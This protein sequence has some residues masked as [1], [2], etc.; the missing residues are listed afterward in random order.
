MFWD[1]LFV[2]PVVTPHLPAVTRALLDYRWRRLD[3]ARQAARRPGW[4][5]AL[6]PWQSGSDGREETP[7][8]LFNL[9]SGRWMPDNSR[10]QRHVGLAV[11][12]NAWQYYQ[13]TGDAA[14]LAERGAELI[15]EVARLFAS[16]ATYD[17]ADDRY[18]IAGVMGPD[19]YHDGYPDAPGARPARQRLHQRAG[20]LGVSRGPSTSSA[21]LGGPDCAELGGAS[22]AATRT[23]SQAGSG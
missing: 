3:A 5:G 6:F 4:Q 12:Y 15:V 17:P 13:A 1:E 18:H 16:L 14:W 9:R 11:A 7:R 8:E 22:R 20:R 10:L 23:S 19:E 21:V 2:L